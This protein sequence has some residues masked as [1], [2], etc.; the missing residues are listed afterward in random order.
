MT[1]SLAQVVGDELR[2]WEQPASPSST[3]KLWPQPQ[4]PEAFGFSILNPD[5]WSDSTKSTLAPLRYGALA[6][7]TTTVTPKCSE[8]L[9]PSAAPRSNPSAYSNPPQPPPRIATRSTSAVP[10]GSSS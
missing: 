1:R 6:E 5:S 4:E 2:Q 8:A 9:S 3:W 7:S 10:A